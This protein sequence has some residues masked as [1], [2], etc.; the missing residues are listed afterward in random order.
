M[1]E[2]LTN[3]Q[4]LD[5]HGRIVARGYSRHMNFDYDK[6]RV[7]TLRLKEWDFYQIHFDGRYV[8]QLTLGHVS[9]A[10]QV[11]ATLIDLATGDKHQISRI[12]PI[13]PAFKRRMPTDPE[14]AHTLQ[15]F[16]RNLHVQFETTDK[17]RRLAFTANDYYGIKA[18]VNLMLT[19]VS[20]FKEKMVIA[21]PFADAKY[22][23]L[24]YKENCFVVN[25][26]VRI[27]EAAYQIHNG[28]GLLDWGR[29]VWPYRHKWTWG[30]GGTVVN[31][32]H[33]GFNIGWGF[34]NTEAATEN[35]FF[36][37]NKL[38]KL[39]EV[40]EVKYNGEIR[41]TDEDRRFV[42]T[43]EPLFDN[44][45]HLRMLWVN[46]TCHQL[47]GRWSGYAV[48]EDGTKLQVPPFLAF[49]EHVRNQW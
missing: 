49:C 18:E 37:D 36:Y 5:S 41:Y 33:F 20:K 26:Y 39:G 3:E 13:R 45:T 16:T 23:Y 48:L 46:N 29:G 12:C 8:L 28:F 24:N 30:N 6:Q 43:V 1:K 32:K 15:Y 9:Y 34:G 7:R 40:Q 25:G 19:N 4:L 44:Y 14:V 22:W 38:Y 17:F 42:F 2:V 27:G 10:M 47:F 11:G 35:A 21:T 31:G